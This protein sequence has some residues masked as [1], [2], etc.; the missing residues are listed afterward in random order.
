MP[1]GVVFLGLP[2]DHERLKDA[3]PGLPMGGAQVAE[4]AVLQ[5]LLRY[6]IAEPLVVVP[7]PTLTRREA[8][9]LLSAYDGHARAHLAFPEELRVPGDAPMAI[10]QA[11]TRLD[12]G[13][14]F[15]SRWGRPEWPLVGLAHALNGAD[16]FNSAILPALRPD[17]F[18][19]SDS[20]ICTSRRAV[21]SWR[22]LQASVSESVPRTPE[23]HRGI[24][25][26]LIPLGVDS[27]GSRPT[28]RAAARQS[29]G[30]PATAT[31]FL[32]FG[33][34]SSRSKMDP[35]VLL[36]GFL[37][38]FGRDPSTTLVIA[39]D[40]TGEDTGRLTARIRALGLDGRVRLVENPSRQVKGLL[41]AAADVFVQLG[42]NTQETF[43]L[44]VVEAMAH[45]LPVIAS[46]W[47]G[48]QD[49]VVDGVTGRLL[50]TTWRSDGYLG[51]TAGFLPEWDL[52]SAL[53]GE[54]SVDF[55]LLVA[56]FREMADDPSKRKAM[57]ARGSRRASE[58]HAWP[59]VVARIDGLL[60]RLARPG[61]AHRT[62]TARCWPPRAN[63]VFGHYATSSS[64]LSGDL[65]CTD[66]P[67]L[68]DAARRIVPEVLAGTGPA[69]GAVHRVDSL[70]D[71]MVRG[72]MRRFEARRLLLL[73]I[74]Y[75]LLAPAPPP[76][77]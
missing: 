75:G 3:N 24:E 76:T 6:S 67:V 10:L 17:L 49:T 9:S 31:V 26:Y 29:L 47:S 73:G 25:P 64:E 44:G 12:E 45:G 46:D 74:K 58:N 53:A 1:Y 7:N 20:L 48:Y 30:L 33:R 60:G 51:D 61:S 2:P 13:A 35:T 59:T 15:R 28:D 21:V 68:L 23:A 63:E 37:A 32:C 19:D 77:G 5:N 56:A 52:G 65:R 39:G 14:V 57:G 70:L 42:D 34:V 43:G 18:G 40:A 36:L 22:R 66:D 62:G 16:A 38:A 69:P 55:G 50:P 41:H 4:H 72:G 11:T 71:A 54:V 27:G 8:R